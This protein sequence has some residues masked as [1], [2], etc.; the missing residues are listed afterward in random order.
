VAV[1]YYGQT[2]RQRNRAYQ[3]HFAS[4]QKLVGFI[5]GLRLKARKKREDL[6]L[7]DQL[8][9]G[10]RGAFGIASRVLD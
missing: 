9:R 1:R 6:G 3:G 5:T 10:L 7:L 2:R 8:P 4:P